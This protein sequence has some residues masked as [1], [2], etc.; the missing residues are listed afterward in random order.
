MTWDL[1]NKRKLVV[2]QVKARGAK[3]RIYY[4]IW[5]TFYLLFILYLF[6]KVKAKGAKLCIKTFEPRSTCY[7]FYS[8]LEKWKLKEPNYYDILV[9]FYLFFIT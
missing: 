9:A 7:L 1:E 2:W 4:D 3:L 8:C 6:G 5:V